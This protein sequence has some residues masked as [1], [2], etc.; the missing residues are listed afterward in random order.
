M[1]SLIVTL[2]FVLSLSLPALATEPAE[3]AA[4]DTPAPGQSVAAPE[5][6]DTAPLA[7]DTAAT[8]Q[9]DLQSAAASLAAAPAPLAEFSL[10]DA[11]IL[12]WEESG[13]GKYI[14]FTLTEEKNTELATITTEHLG[15]AIQINLNDNFIIIPKVTT[16]MD[17]QNGFVLNA[18][19][20]KRFEIIRMLDPDK[21]KASGTEISLH[22]GPMPDPAATEPPAEM[23]K[24]A[25]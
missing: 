20:G 10:T 7:P 13:E 11:D 15:Q 5:T 14:Y 9:I 25:P 24:D 8:D 3:Q 22:A 19:K 12:A 1:R 23:V 21:K 18:A 2:A 4:T 17:Q 16:I 6:V